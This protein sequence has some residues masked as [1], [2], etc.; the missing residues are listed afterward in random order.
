VHASQ[1]KSSK[2]FF[3]LRKETTRTRE[4]FK[5]VVGVE[6]TEMTLELKIQIDYLN[7]VIIN[8]V[9][10][11]TIYT[12]KYV[13]HTTPFTLRL[14]QYTTCFGSVE[15]SSGTCI[16]VKTQILNQTT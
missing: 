13:V 12:C 3:F 9:R 5:A 6:E 1:V 8:T 10:H 14:C 15:P 4:Y 11:T 7:T 16:N 2:V